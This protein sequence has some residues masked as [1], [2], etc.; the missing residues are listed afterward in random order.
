MLNAHLIPAV[1]AVRAGKSSDADDARDLKEKLGSIAKTSQADQFLVRID[2]AVG[3]ALLT[4]V[5][6]IG[7]TVVSSAAQWNTVTAEATL[8]QI[9]ALTRI[10]GCA[11]LRWSGGDVKR[12]EA[13]D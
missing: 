4:K 2:V 6:A 3:D 13:S 1:E 5:K 12:G 8:A 9:D 7:A 11:A 10:G